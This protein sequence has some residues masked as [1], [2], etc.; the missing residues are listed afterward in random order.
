MAPLLITKLRLQTKSLLDLINVIQLS[1]ELI[2]T[3]LC[4]V[5]EGQLFRPNDT[6]VW[7]STDDK[8]K[9]LEVDH[10]TKASELEERDAELVAR[11]ERLAKQLNRSPEI[12]PAKEHV[13]AHTIL[14]YEYE[15]VKFDTQLEPGMFECPWRK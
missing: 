12:S 13:D 8:I 4:G 1:E 11:E 5:F 9:K 7:V 14:R 2:E 10:Y 15:M 3:E 6:K